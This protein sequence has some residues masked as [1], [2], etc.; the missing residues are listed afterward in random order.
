[1]TA[2]RLTIEA[3]GLP[4]GRQIGR[5]LGVVSVAIAAAALLAT[6]LPGLEE[7]PRR[8]AGADRGWMAAALIL[9]LASTACFAFAFHG[10]YDR[11]SSPRTSAGM[12][13]AVQ[14]MNVVLPSG[15]AGGLAVG[16]VLL[17]RAGVPRSFAA[18][19]T[20]ALFL[21][22][23]LVSFAAVVIA[24]FG[25]AMG[26]LSGDATL[27]TTLIPGAAALLLIV[28]V[29]ALPRSASKQTSVPGGRLSKALATTREHLRDGVASSAELLRS[30]DRLVIGGA[31]GYFAFDV[32]ALAAA[33]HAVGS[34]RLPVG[35]LVLAYTLGHGGAIV[36]I[37]GS[38]E[39]G[40]IGMFVLYGMSLPT[41]TAAVLAYRALH[42]GVPVV[43]GV[44]GMADVRRG[45]RDNARP[46]AAKPAPSARPPTAA[47]PA[48]AGDRSRSPSMADCPA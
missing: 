41:A 46:A 26:A 39:G 11:R 18:S 43:L 33:F 32:A 7:I 37:P 19:R 27:V 36:P 29:F 6:Q 12:S 25:V 23:S 4:T 44:I 21:I 3:A 14:G 24:G 47:E 30:G 8:L 15:G 28:A 31:I 5:K 2:H 34:A 9:E 13:M 1:M 17:D 16:A 10:V 45:L 22:T 42:A 40:L 48:R 20:V 38:A 35:L